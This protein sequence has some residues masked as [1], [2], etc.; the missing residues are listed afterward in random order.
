[1]HHRSVS[2]RYQKPNRI[3]IMKNKYS[4][5]INLAVRVCVIIVILRLSSTKKD[6]KRMANAFKSYIGLVNSR[7]KKEYTSSH[8]EQ[9]SQRL[10][11]E[12]VSE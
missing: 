8:A 5:R 3:I 9:L 10:L 6:T 2:M 1:M 7:A 4:G 11:V 12:R